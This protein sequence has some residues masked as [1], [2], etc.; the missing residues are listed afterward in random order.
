MSNFFGVQRAPSNL[1][2]AAT[3]GRRSKREAAAT[4]RSLAAAVFAPL[5]ELQAPTESVIRLLAV[6]L[7]C[8]HQS[9]RRGKR[10]TRVRS[11]SEALFTLHKAAVR[12]ISSF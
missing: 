5:V 6:E 9:Y 12:R 1:L 2:R 10:S 11:Q 3:A 4:F 8:Q 7:P